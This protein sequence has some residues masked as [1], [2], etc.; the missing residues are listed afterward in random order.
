MVSDIKKHDSLIC[1]LCSSPGLIEFDQFPNFQRITSDCRP[2][3]AGGR[4]AVC[5]N[6]GTVQKIVDDSF[7]A[8]IDQIYDTYAM[9][10][11]AEGE[12]HLFFDQASGQSTPR[13]ERILSWV[14]NFF[15]FKMT[16]RLLDIGCGNGALLKAMAR[17]QP[18]WKLAGSELTDHYQQVVENIPGC[19][20]L[21]TCSLAEI[22]G[23]FD[24][25]TMNNVIEHIPSPSQ[26]LH[27]ISTILKP[28]GWLLIETVNL[29]Q[30]PFDLLQADHVNHFT[31]ETL[32]DLLNRSGYQVIGIWDNCIP[33]EIT[34]LAS[35]GSTPN[36]PPLNSIEQVRGNVQRNLDWLKQTSDYVRQASQKNSLGLFG[37]TIVA[38]WLFAELEGK[39]DFFVDEDPHKVNKLYMG[40]PVITPDA[41]PDGSAV[42]LAFSTALAEK[43]HLRLQEAYPHTK[44]ICPPNRSE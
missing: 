37:T 29:H 16:G 22:P 15:P 17:L 11:L 41:I 8:T 32:S 20:G 44:F 23:M 14:R 2:W 26:M 27:E 40:K 21:Y 35:R 6:C 33:K 10:E 30:N 24:L 36:P 28:D 1:H 31:P 25:I 7:K 38:T 19:E 18:D 5:P 3:P 42:F 4:L 9:Y 34:L 43:I 13:S 39:V 12:D